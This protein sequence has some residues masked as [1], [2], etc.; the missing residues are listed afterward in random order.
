VRWYHLACSPWLAFFKSL[1]AKQGWR[2]GWRGWVIAFATL[3]KVFL[4]YAF[5]FENRRA[6][7]P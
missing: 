3:T 6:R 4:K 2:D 5:V 1:V 7:R